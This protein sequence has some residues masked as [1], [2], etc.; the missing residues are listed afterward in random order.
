MDKIFPTALKGCGAKNYF[1]NMHILYIIGKYLC[2][3]DDAV[4]HFIKGW[5]DN[6]RYI[7]LSSP[8]EVGNVG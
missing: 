7:K 8:V 3:P 2:S 5:G 6:Y 1:N 4:I